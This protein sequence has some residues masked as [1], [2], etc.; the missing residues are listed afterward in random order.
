MSLD[1]TYFS[2]LKPS[3]SDNIKAVALLYT[4]CKRVVVYVYNSQEFVDLYA[5]YILNKCVERQ[6][7]AFKKGFLMVTNESPLKYLFRPEE[8]ELLVCGS[9][10]RKS[11]LIKFYCFTGSVVFTDIVSLVILQ[12]LDFEALEKTTEYDGGY[13]KD[14]QIIKQVRFFSFSRPRPL[15]FNILL[16]SNSRRAVISCLLSCLLYLFFTEISGKLF[17][18]LERSR[19]G[20]FFSSRL[21][22]TEHQ[23]AALQK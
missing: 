7:T 13:S 9:R 10:V 5:D 16:F 12:K 22:Q 3:K 14:S 15:C 18:H 21:A 11:C 17:T 8:V 4:V 23:L 19:R 1:S 6:F 20:C 2:P